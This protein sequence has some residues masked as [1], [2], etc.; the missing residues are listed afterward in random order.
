MM[1]K[2]SKQT[3]VSLKLADMRQQV[4][5]AREERKK[6]STLFPG[7][8][9]SLYDDEQSDGKEVKKDVPNWK[10]LIKQDPYL[11]E[12]KNIIVDMGK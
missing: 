11:S 5:V 3:T 8:K 6:L 10:E 2:R 9:T 12:A 4:E 7:Y 1:D